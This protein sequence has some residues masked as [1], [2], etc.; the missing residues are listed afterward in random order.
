MQN[1]L[2]DA[3]ATLTWS[4]VSSTTEAF[5]LTATK[6]RDPL[7]EC[8]GT[9]GRGG[10]KNIDCGVRGLGSNPESCVAVGKSVRTMAPQ[11]SYV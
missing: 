5:S 8:G 9:R 6:H 3:A 7:I 1:E 10:G 4:W 11:W 2:E